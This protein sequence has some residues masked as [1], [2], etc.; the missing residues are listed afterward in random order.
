MEYNSR[1]LTYQN[2]RGKEVS[3]GF[4]IEYNPKTELRA[5][6]SQS[7][8][9]DTRI[10]ISFLISPRASNINWNRVWLKQGFGPHLAGEASQKYIPMWPSFFDF[11]INSPDSEVGNLLLSP[12][13]ED[14][15]ALQGGSK[16]W[17]LFPPIKSWLMGHISCTLRMNT[18]WSCS[19]KR[20]EEKKIW[21]K[22]KISENIY[23]KKKEKVTRGLGIRAHSIGFRGQE[24]K[25]PEHWGLPNALCKSH[26]FP[27]Q[28]SSEDSEMTF[29]SHKWSNSITSKAHQN[30][31]LSTLKLAYTC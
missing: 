14:I 29:L 3:R 23:S 8:I 17:H 10:C 16:N 12:K 19:R 24:E 4:W 13:P 11:D 15:Q 6:T 22:M 2:K 18:G 27:W 21:R 7:Y 30:P 26:L 20:K 31:K 1:T 28:L 25:V 5:K 9:L